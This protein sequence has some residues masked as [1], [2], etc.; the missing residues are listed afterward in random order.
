MATV[1]VFSSK[2]VK[3]L[4]CFDTLDNVPFLPVQVVE[5]EDEDEDN[6]FA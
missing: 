5:D 1:K 4:E 2:G 6:P 3:I